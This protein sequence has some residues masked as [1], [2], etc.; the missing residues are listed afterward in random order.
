MIGPET[1]RLMRLPVPLQ[2]QVSHI[3]NQTSSCLCRGKNNDDAVKTPASDHAR[4]TSGVGAGYVCQW[5]S[6]WPYGKGDSRCFV[7]QD[8][9][10]IAVY[11]CLRLFPAC[12]SPL[13]SRKE[14]DELFSDLHLPPQTV[15]LWEVN[16]YQLK[17]GIWINIPVIQLKGIMFQ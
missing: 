8:L 4:E 6:G 17:K 14:E 11:S 5:V 1:L 12:S 7:I 3:L 10:A 16:H 2:L 9:L 15:S 13:S